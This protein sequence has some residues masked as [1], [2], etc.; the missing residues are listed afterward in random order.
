MSGRNFFQLTLDILN[1]KKSYF[2]N[3]KIQ[4]RFS[5]LDPSG[6]AASQFTTLD[7]E[8]PLGYPPRKSGR[9]RCSV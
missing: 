6:P 1:V 5:I 7:I 2:E 4:L 3:Q 8:N 9:G